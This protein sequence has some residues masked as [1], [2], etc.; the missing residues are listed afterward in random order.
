MDKWTPP[1]ESS[2]WV[3]GSTYYFHT[4]RS[5]HGQR[6]PIS[7]PIP[8]RAWSAPLPSPTFL[9][10]PIIYHRKRYT[11]GPPDKRWDIPPR[12]TSLPLVPFRSRAPF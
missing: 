8:L 1:P 3:Q 10:A 9:L 6:V 4:S 2:I 12:P 11:A 7:I 5:V